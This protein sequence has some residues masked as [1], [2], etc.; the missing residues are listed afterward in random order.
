MVG[1]ESYLGWGFPH[2]LSGRPN[3][4]G[5]TSRVFG[6]FGAKPRGSRGQ[7]E[8]YRRSEISVKSFLSSIPTRRSLQYWLDLASIR[9]TKL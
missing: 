1:I 7:T 4:V 9:V 5:R 8:K 6:D 3:G 2:K